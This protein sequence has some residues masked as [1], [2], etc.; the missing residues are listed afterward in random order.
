MSYER[1]SMDSE[2][3]LAKNLD[4]PLAEKVASLFTSFEVHDS[5]IWYVAAA[6]LNN[7]FEPKKIAELKE[8]LMWQ[9]DDRADVY[10]HT[11]HQGIAEIDRGSLGF[12]LPTFSESFFI[13]TQAEF[14]KRIALESAPAQT[15]PEES[16]HREPLIQQ[17]EDGTTSVLDT[18]RRARENPPEAKRNNNQPGHKKSDYD[19]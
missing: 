4:E 10:M 13:D 5:R 9:Y 6:E 15:K 12:W 8:N 1:D 2:R 19:L 14:L 18:L 17:R 16:P 7:P 3:G 11:P